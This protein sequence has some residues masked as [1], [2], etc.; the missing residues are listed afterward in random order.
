MRRGGL[1]LAGI[2]FVLVVAGSA[3]GARWLLAPA[4]PTGAQ[5][6]FKVAPGSSLGEIAHGLERE[7]LVRSADAVEWIAHELEHV[8]EQMEGV[9]VAETCA[10]Y[11]RL[12]ETVPGAVDTIRARRAGR[13][14]LT[15]VE[16][17]G[18]SVVAR[19]DERLGRR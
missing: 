8:I 10:H 2:A 14:V 4:D 7:G 5:V 3:A 15:E 16:Q 18:R 13:A 11:P 6:V 17:G 1:T 19:V 9:R 12:C